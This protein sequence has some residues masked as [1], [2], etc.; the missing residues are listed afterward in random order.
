[1]STC[2]KKLND[3]NLVLRCCRCKSICL[4]TNFYKNKNKKDG[5]YSFCTICMNSYENEYIKKRT[6]TD[7]NYRLI[8]NTRY[9]THHALNG[10]MKSSSTKNLLGTDIDIY[11]NWIEIQMTPDINWKKWIS[12]M[13]DL[14]LHSI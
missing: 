3:Y 4:K 10:K 13:W 8:D 9:R 5:V 1:M 6:K 12:I 2:I 11:R 14:V 7:V